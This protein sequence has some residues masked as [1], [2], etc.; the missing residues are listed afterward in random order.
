VEEARAHEVARLGQY[1]AG[2]RH[3]G[4]ARELADDALHLVERIRQVDVGEDTVPAARGEHATS[5]GVSLAAV[6]R[7]AHH[8]N[9]LARA[10]EVR[11]HE[12]GDVARAVVDEEDFET[13]GILRGEVVDR[14]EGGW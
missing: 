7:V 8:A 11:E 3:V 6:V 9:S 5:H 10:R 14:L 4:A 1:T 2:D 13:I 12:L